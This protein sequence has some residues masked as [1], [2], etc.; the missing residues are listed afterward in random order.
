M[1]ALDPA[2]PDP[3][4]TAVKSD[5]LVPLN[6]FDPFDPITEPAVSTDADP[7]G[8]VQDKTSEVM[9]DGQSAAIAEKLKVIKHNKNM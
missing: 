3:P 8:K 2:I 1:T 4:D 9:T 7:E 5:P 6:P